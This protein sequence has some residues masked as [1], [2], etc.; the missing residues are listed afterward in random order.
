ML[1][2]GDVHDPSP[3]VPKDDEHE[4]QAEGGRWYDEQVG[5][6]DLARVIGQE[7]SPRL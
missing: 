5:G 7:R 3:V 4:Q 1:G 2:D 6:H